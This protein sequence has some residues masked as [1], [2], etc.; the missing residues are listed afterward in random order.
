RVVV[1]Q[2]DHEVPLGHRAAHQ[3]VA[4]RALRIG[5]REV[6]V[7]RHSHLALEQE[8]LARRALALATAV[9]E[10]VALA[11]G[12]IQNG[13]L[14]AALDFLA[15]RLEADLHRIEA[16]VARSVSATPSGTV[17]GPAGTPD[18]SPDG[19]PSSAATRILGER[20]LSPW[21]R[22]SASVQRRS[23]FR[24][25]CPISVSPSERTRPRSVIT[26]EASQP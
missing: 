10:V 4:P 16:P 11:E 1:Q 14:G 6:R 25:G 24:C 8:A 7:G 21:A 5:E 12:G 19:N 2:F 23:E 13:L 22:T 15:D 17:P 18:Q 26:S 9:G 3:R 20:I